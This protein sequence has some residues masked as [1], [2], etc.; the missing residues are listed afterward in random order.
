MLLRFFEAPYRWPLADGQTGENPIGERL[1][2]RS[3]EPGSPDQAP[4][5]IRYAQIRTTSPEPG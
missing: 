2:I 1:P 4:K 3:A 5:S